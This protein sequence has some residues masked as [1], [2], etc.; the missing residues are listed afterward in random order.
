[1]VS[2]LSA[3]ALS[4][5]IPTDPKTFLIPM[6]TTCFA[7]EEA[8]LTSSNDA[9]K[10]EVAGKKARPG[11]KGKRFKRKKGALPDHFA[12]R[13]K[14]HTGR[15]F[16]IKQDINALIQHVI[17]QSYLEC[18]EDLRHYANKVTF[19]NDLKKDI[20][21]S[22]ANA[23][24]RLS[25]VAGKDGDHK[26]KKPYV[27]SVFSGEYTGQ[28]KTGNK[29]KTCKTKAE[30]EAYIEE[31]EGKLNSVGDD[32]QLANVDLQNIL[33]K[34]QQAIQTLSNVSKSCHDTAMSVIRKMG[35]G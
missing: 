6:D 25:G 27:A 32:A 14:K 22:L 35:G 31:L 13:W 34:Q 30:L 8:Q 17:R 23:R 5:E 7:A 33:Q 28:G 19:Y 9:L 15:A 24:E 12:R 29:K 16:K 1:M 3:L 2:D 4:A 18:S 21:D 26:F 11:K 10:A 20:R